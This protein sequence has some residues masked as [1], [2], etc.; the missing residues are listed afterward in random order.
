MRAGTPRGAVSL[1]AGRAGHGWLP[2]GGKNICFLRVSVEME[3]PVQRGPGS[4]AAHLPG[5]PQLSARALSGLLRH[6]EAVGSGVERVQAVPSW[7]QRCCRMSLELLETLL[8][9]IYTHTCIYKNIYLH[10]TFDCVS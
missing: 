1:G 8:A 5:A 9:S 10:F 3:Y 6:E 2:G 4:V 7:W